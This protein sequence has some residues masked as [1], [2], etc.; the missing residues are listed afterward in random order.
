MKSGRIINVTNNKLRNVISKVK[1][2]VLFAVL[3]VNVMSMMGFCADLNLATGV[4]WVGRLAMGILGVMG[5]FQLVPAIISIK[6]IAKGEDHG[7]DQGGMSKQIGKIL[8]ALLL[9]LG[10]SLILG[11]FGINSLEIGTHFFGDL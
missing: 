4:D 6:D 7:Q 9:I 1:T 2:K 3:A 10:P 5:A 11:A 8:A